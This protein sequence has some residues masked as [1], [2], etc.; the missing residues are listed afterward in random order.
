MGTDGGSAFQPLVKGWSH[1]W[2]AGSAVRK[3]SW[4]QSGEQGQPL[5]SK[6]TIT[7][8]TTAFREQWLL[9][10]SH[11]LNLQQ[12]AFLVNYNSEPYSEDLCLFT[13]SRFLTISEMESFL[14]PVLLRLE[15]FFDP[16]KHE[17]FIPEIRIFT[18]TEL[19]QI[20]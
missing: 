16:L 19:T 1:C 13:L 8:N 5:I 7:S 11:Q 18:H 17:I 10:D 15:S 9:L 3:K 2:S 12:E 14:M 6:S 4:T 20:V